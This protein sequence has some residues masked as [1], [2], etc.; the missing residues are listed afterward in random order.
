M[1]C[2]QKNRDAQR[3]GTVQMHGALSLRKISSA[4][5]ME[6][7]EKV[8]VHSPNKSSDHRV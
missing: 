5:L 8:V 6:F 4:T 1:M 2:L 7:A 3:E